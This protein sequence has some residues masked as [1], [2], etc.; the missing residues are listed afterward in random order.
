MI[1]IGNKQFFEAKE[2]TTSETRLVAL[3]DVVEFYRGSNGKF[4]ALI[5]IVT[6]VHMIVTDKV[7]TSLLSK[8]L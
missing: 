7:L 1:T 3:D 2:H 8:T 4:C 6:G 5:R